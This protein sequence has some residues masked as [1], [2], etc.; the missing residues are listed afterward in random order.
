MRRILSPLLLAYLARAALA[1]EWSVLEPFQRSLTRADFESACSNLY[2]PQ[3]GLA[4][5]LQF[6]T[7][8]VAI[9]SDAARTGAP[10]FRLEF[11]DQP[12]EAPPHPPLAGFRIAIDPGHIGGAWARAEDRFFF[13]DRNDWY[14][15]EA[16]LNLLVARLLKTRLEEG[17]AEVSLTKNDFEPVTTKRP[18]DFVSGIERSLG[19]YE[20]FTELPDLFREASR[21]DSIRKRSEVAFFRG[22]EI[23]ARALKVNTEIKPDLTLCIHFNAR[24]TENPRELVDDR[25]LVVFV[26]GNYLPGEI[27]DPDQR[28]R[29]FQK[30]LEGSSAAE[31]AIAESIVERF[32]AAT[33]LP[34]AYHARSGPL[35]PVGTN[36]YLYARNLAANRLFDGPVVYLE[37]Y[38]MNSVETYRRIQAG[39]YTGEREIE[40]VMRPSIFREYADAVAA[41][42][43]AAF[44][45]DWKFAR[46]KFQ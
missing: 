33:G 4:K 7:N 17:G 25:G 21:L 12:T 15:Q 5:Y 1:T 9:F 37:P 29:L 2:A 40:G 27:A 39:D 3:G 23:E 42:I 19:R 46:K 11:A 26:H 10:A 18:A 34:P 44:S 31:R 30:L 35:H 6:E 24:E 20:Y 45:N 14:V 41:G 16:A 32:V 13:A 36:D 22:A 43:R 38:F 28:L 8:A